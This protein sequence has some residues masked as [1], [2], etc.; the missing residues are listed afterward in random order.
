MLQQETLQLSGEMIV[1]Q[2]DRI[3]AFYKTRAQKDSPKLWVKVKLPIPCFCNG[4]PVGG[5]V[6]VRNFLAIMEA[7]V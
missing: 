5:A 1:S 3:L 4:L 7:F 6:A 2:N